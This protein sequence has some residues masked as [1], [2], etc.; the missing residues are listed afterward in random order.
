MSSRANGTQIPG[1]RWE[2]GRPMPG[3]M[4][5]LAEHWG[6]YP[7]EWVAIRDGVLLGHA[8]FLDDLERKIGSIRGIFVTKMV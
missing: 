2:P 6:E 8:P 7:G 4:E 5:W 1:A 3:A